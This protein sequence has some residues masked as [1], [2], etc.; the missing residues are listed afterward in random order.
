MVD[1]IQSV[2]YKKYVESKEKEAQEFLEF[3]E[4]NLSKP[5]NKSSTNRNN[6]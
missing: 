2:N 3:V 6:N 5:K 1:N 4:R